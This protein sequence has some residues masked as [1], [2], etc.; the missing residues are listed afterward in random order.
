MREDNKP[1]TSDSSNSCLERSLLILLYIFY[2]LLGSESL[3]LLRVPANTSR[4]FSSSSPRFRE[5][6]PRRRPIPSENSMRPI[7][8]NLDF[9]IEDKALFYLDFKA[10]ISDLNN[11]NLSLCPVSKLLITLS[12]SFTPVIGNLEAKV[13]RSINFFRDFRFWVAWTLGTSWGYLLMVSSPKCPCYRSLR[14]SLSFWHQNFR[15]SKSNSPVLMKG[16]MP[17]LSQKVERSKMKGLVPKLKVSL[18]P[19]P[20]TAIGV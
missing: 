13:G 17:K 10:K 6:S 16:R 15:A 18:P 9:K 5:V 11:V 1:G 14:P 12:E 4:S 20:N 3:V 8:D 2:V 19:A 7:C